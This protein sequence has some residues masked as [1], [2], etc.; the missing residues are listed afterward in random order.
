VPARQL[1]YGPDQRLPNSKDLC[2][3]LSN[4][5]IVESERARRASLRWR[6]PLLQGTNPP[7]GITGPELAHPFKSAV[8]ASKQAA[9]NT[10]RYFAIDKGLKRSARVRA[11]PRA[12]MPRKAPAFG[13]QIG[14]KAQRIFKQLPRA[15]TPCRRA[16]RVRA[17]SS[18]PFVSIVPTLPVGRTP[19]PPSTHLRDRPLLDDRVERSVLL[20]LVAHS[21]RAI[22][23]ANVRASE[24]TRTWLP[25]GKRFQLRR[26]STQCG[27]LSATLAHCT[28]DW[29]PASSSIPDL[30]RAHG[31]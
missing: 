13:C 26:A 7:E 8:G 11:K 25:Y 18:P 19:I 9:G 24:N 6:Q 2:Q 3:R 16:G 17:P 29:R 27:Q 20:L 30:S 15:A 23:V 4:Q 14:R 28:R 22:G 21:T 5:P 10:I 12:N 31:S 1:S